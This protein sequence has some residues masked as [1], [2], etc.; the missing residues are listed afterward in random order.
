MVVNQSR[1]FVYGRFI[2]PRLKPL[3][4]VPFIPPVPTRSDTEKL[5]IEVLREYSASE[6]IGKVY[7]RP[8]P[9]P[10]WQSVNPTEALQYPWFSWVST[11]QRALYFEMEAS[12]FWKVL[13]FRTESDESGPYLAVALQYCE[14]SQIPMWLKGFVARRR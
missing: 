4:G 5:A 3:L 10:N 8:I 13:H 2:W 14:L 9:L 1:P 7:H 11:A 6:F 12:G